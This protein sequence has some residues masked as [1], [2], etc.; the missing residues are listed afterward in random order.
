MKI[1]F[2]LYSK[3]PGADFVG[4]SRMRLE[5]FI[6]IVIAA[7]VA[8][9]CLSGFAFFN[10]RD[11]LPQWHDAIEGGLVFLVILAVFLLWKMVD[12]IHGLTQL[13]EAHPATARAYLVSANSTFVKTYCEHIMQQ[14][15]CMT[16]GEADMLLKHLTTR[17][18]IVRLAAYYE[19]HAPLAVWSVS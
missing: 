14:G 4:A 15:R 10:L 6:P 7:L 8:I 5:R 3:P 12:A 17:E 2:D 9:V 13:T 11:T 18:E 1:V 16:M 19:E